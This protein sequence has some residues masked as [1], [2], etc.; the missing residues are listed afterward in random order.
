[1]TAALRKELQ[2]EALSWEGT[3][4][5]HQQMVKG[6]DGGVDCAKYVAAVALQVGLVTREVFDT[7]PPYPR[8][9]AIHHE[10]PLLSETMKLIGCKKKRT[11]NANPG[12]IVVFKIGRVPSHLG[13]MLGGQYEGCFIH[14]CAP[15]LGKVTITPLEAQWRKRL[16]EVYRFPGV[17]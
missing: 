6:P 3:P 1:V 8:E 17:K 5:L 11:L 7:I 14:A 13:I 10:I 4:Y 9:W 12:D 15:P 16:I 2:Q